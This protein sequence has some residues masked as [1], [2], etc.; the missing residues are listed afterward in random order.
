MNGGWDTLMK[1][2]SDIRKKCG[3]QG[4]EAA[5]RMEKMHTDYSQLIFKTAK[6]VGKLSAQ[7][8]LERENITDTLGIIEE[9]RKNNENMTVDDLEA[10]QA[11]TAKLGEWIETEEMSQ[12]IDE[13]KKMNK[14]LDDDKFKEEWGELATKAA[15]YEAKKTLKKIGWILL[16]AVAIIGVIVV[17]AFIICSTCGV[18][19][20]VVAGAAVVVQSAVASTT[21]AA[22]T[23]GTAITAGCA[24]VAGSAYKGWKHVK[25]CQKEQAKIKEGAEKN[26]Y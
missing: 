24:V 16:G 19:A 2:L 11:S 7:C 8:K 1:Q 5:D 3:A 26:H 10:Y 4:E 12:I 23:I 22:V 18:A 15:A 21:V 9:G 25:D 13:W 17:V 20:P 14:Q 6:S